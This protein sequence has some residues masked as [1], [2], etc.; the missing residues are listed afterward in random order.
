MLKCNKVVRENGVITEEKTKDVTERFEIVIEKKLNKIITK[1]KELRTIHNDRI[2]DDYIYEVQ[3][4]IK[5]IRS[6]Y[7]F[8]R[9][10][11]YKGYVFDYRVHPPKMKAHI[12]KADPNT[13]RS[14][15]RHYYL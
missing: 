10:M 8:D 2:L 4:D 1:L 3:E 5:L 15:T 7:P 6:D 9:R 13:K 14:V 11:N 12:H